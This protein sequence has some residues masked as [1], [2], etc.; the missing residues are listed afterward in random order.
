MRTPPFALAVAS[1]CLVL[2][3]QPVCAQAPAYQAKATMTDSTAAPLAATKRVVIS[4][5]V[6][7]FQASTSN[8]T[9]TQGLFA[10]KADSS[11]TLQMPEADAQLLA[12][13][14]DDIYAQLKADLQA[15][16][17]ELVPEAALLASANHGKLI[18]MAGYTN[19]SR[20]ANQHGDVWLVSPAGLK[21]YLTYNAE[22]GKFASANKTYIKGWLAGMMRNSSTEGG[23][24]G[25]KQ[26]EIYEAP[27]L[28]VALAKELNAHVVKATYVVTL[29][30]AVADATRAGTRNELSGKAQAQLGLL[31]AQSRIAFRTPG[32]NA[33]GES[34][35][36]SYTANFGDNAPPAKDGDVVVA[37]GTSLA[38]GG[39]YFS[40][41]EPETKTG[42]L[43]GG[44][45]SGF[46]TGADKQFIFTVAI[47]DPAAY[48]AD[49]L[50]LL[51]AAQRE[52]L[53]LVKP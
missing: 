6:V 11:S 43:L 16:G 17:F 33:K 2:A 50:A 46:G 34:A 14:A 24:T 27:G 23:P 38:G 12:G 29:G 35:S 41:V 22:S 13:I 9:S 36:T 1:A 3:T 45:L 49:A 52:M 32:A 18:Q 42:S 37:L 15:S 7:S 40:M 28:E 47:T 20:Y 53:S 51:K 48:R 31:A 30:S 19:L 5:V 4:N 25:M 8:K 39:G 21:P 26:A 44:L 10:N